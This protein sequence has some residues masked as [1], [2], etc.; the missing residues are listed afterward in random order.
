MGAAEPRAVMLLALMTL[1][2]CA[3]EPAPS[4][5]TA[6]DFSESFETHDPL[7][8]GWESIEGVWEIV[9]E[10]QAPLGE[11]VIQIQ[12][13]TGPGLLLANGKGTFADFN[14]TLYF[15]NATATGGELGLVFRYVDRDNHEVAFLDTDASTV[16]IVEVQAGT[17]QERGVRPAP[18]EAFGDWHQMQVRV[19][20]FTVTVRLD[21]DQP[22][23][24][25]NLAIPVGSL[26]LWA[27]DAANAQFDV[28]S[29][30]AG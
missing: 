9:D 5:A 1:A 3:S 17:R 18:A 27:Q 6:E 12:A 15:R 4:V 25:E 21:L 20:G 23:V 8:E 10:A 13:P 24:V 30:R 14:A 11:H 19:V 26:G 29:A 28:L 16:R 22:L 2:G 7:P